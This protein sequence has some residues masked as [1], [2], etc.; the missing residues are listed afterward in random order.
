MSQEEHILHTLKE[1]REWTAHAD[2]QLSRIK[3]ALYGLTVILVTTILL[4]VF[5]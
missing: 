1:M 4:V 5:K 2:R 3:W